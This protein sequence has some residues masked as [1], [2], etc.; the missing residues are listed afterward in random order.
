M[1]A[2]SDRQQAMIN[3]LRGKVVAVVGLGKSGLAAARLLDA[4]GAQVRLVDQKPESELVDLASPLQ[5]LNTQIFGGNRFAE[6]I[7][8]AECVVLSPGVPPSLEAINQARI[9]GVP[10]ISEIELAS[11][12]LSIPLVAVTGTNGKS[13]TV[14][15]LGRIFEESGRQAFVGGNLGTPLSEAALTMFRHEANHA[16]GPAPYDLAVVEVSSFQ[17]ETIDRFCPHV[18]VIL[19][20]TPD[21]LDRHASFADY[22]A[23]KG[24][25]FENQTAD[26][27]AV[28]NVDDNQL[29]PLHESIQ[30]LS[31]G[32]SMKERLPNGVFLNDPLIMASMS[33]QT[34]PIMPIEEIQLLGAHN[35][36]NVLAAV[37]V[38]LLCECPISTI[39]RAVGT[40]RGREHALELVRKRQG[41]MFV[42]D[43]KGT[44]VD[45]TIKALESFTQPVVIILGGKDKGSDFTQ[46]REALQQ[47]AKSIVLIGEASESIAKAI[48][49]IGDIRQAQSLS[50]AVELASHLAVSGD[51]VLL[52]PACASFD[53]FRDYL[54]RGQQFRDLVNALPA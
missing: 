34:Y 6:G 32:F 18:A 24:R 41:V 1:V 16:G 5:H 26:D 38:G 44:N 47:H 29:L 9:K 46:L 13:T 20:V 54:D 10:V 2:M 42:N 4:V 25:I 21:H 31:V 15:L 8:P 12:F 19:N 37:A 22:I 43:S 7:Q 35:V 23:A 40:Y 51:V 17:L 53:M 27:F 52:S 50:Q 45:A 30:A 39:R 33:G 28:L 3:D 49:G 11:W 14:S 48:M 36:A